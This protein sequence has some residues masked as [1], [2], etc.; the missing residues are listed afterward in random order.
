VDTVVACGVGCG[1]DDPTPFGIASYQNRLARQLWIL[2]HLNGSVEGVEVKVNYGTGAI[3]WR[4]GIN[5]ILSFT[6]S[7]RFNLKG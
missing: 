6:S 4:R 2:Q 5:V 7:A 3:R 1:G